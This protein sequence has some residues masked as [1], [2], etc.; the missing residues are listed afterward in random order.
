[1]DIHS[2]QLTLLGQLMNK[3]SWKQLKKEVEEI[4]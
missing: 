1:M 3:K 4:T 2:C